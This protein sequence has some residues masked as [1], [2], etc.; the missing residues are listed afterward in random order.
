[1][2]S[3]KTNLVIVESPAKTKS[4]QKYLGDEF[5]VISSKGHIVDLPKSKLGIDVDNNFTPLYE[6]MTGKSKVIKELISQAKRSKVIY[7]ATDLDREGEA[8]AWHIASVLGGLNKDGKVDLQ[9]ESHYKRV[10]FSEIT[11]D[12][13]LKAFE[14]P[15]GFNFDLVDAYQARRVLDRLVGYK[16]SPFLWKKIQYGLSAGRVQSVALRLIVE[17]EKERINFKK[18]PYYRI[19]ALV[20]HNSKELKAELTHIDEEVVETKQTLD[21]FAGPYTY[22]STSINTE[23]KLNSQIT[24]ISGVQTLTVNSIEQKTIQKS[25]PAP[26]TTASLQRTA[27]T[28]LHISPKQTMRLAQQLYEQGYITYHRTDSTNLS[29]DF[30]KNLREYIQK[31]FGEKYLP[32]NTKIYASKQKNAQEAHEAIRPTQISDEKELINEITSN[33]SEEACELFQLISNRTTACQMENAQFNTQKITF[34]P[35]EKTNHQYL[36]SSSGSVILFDGFMRIWN[37]EETEQELPVLKEKQQVQISKIESS[38]HET[39]PPPRY[40]EASLIKEMETHGIGRPSTYAPTIGTIESR[41]Y[42]FMENGYLIPTDIGNAVSNLLS[43]HFTNI[44]DLNFT[45]EMEEKLDIVAEGKITWQKIIADFYIPFEKELTDKDKSL[46][47]KDYKILEE[48][49]EKCPDCNHNLVLKLGKYGKFYSCSNFP[50]CKYAKPF[51]ETIG[52]K[53]PD[54]K[55]GDIITRRTKRG[56][57]FYGCSKYPDC[58]YA[59]WDDPRKTKAEPVTPSSNQE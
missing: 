13:I 27:S 18:S 51:V 53:C 59:S 34:I 30:V 44:V 32:P 11:K 4:I 3:P 42:T 54:C 1:M 41:N 58:K 57:I 7:L 29:V 15:R 55:D 21:L 47:R 5:T 35:T 14:S 48:L 52:L 10:V 36:F 17:R 20:N 33:V 8:I 12:A 43:D 56:K 22:S 16:L 31:S 28:R 9:N 50:E 23:A 49:T 26:F 24:D 39:T 6:E 46:D 37:G 25:P 45:A 2:K 19:Y 40:S 38:N